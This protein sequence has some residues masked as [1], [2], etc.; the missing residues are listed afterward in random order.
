MVG[1][2]REGRELSGGGG[3]LGK[4]NEFALTDFHLF[5]PEAWSKVRC[6]SGR[7]GVTMRLWWPWRL[8]SRCGRKRATRKAIPSWAVGTSRNVW[9]TTYQVEAATGL[10]SMRESKRATKPGSRI[11]TGKSAGRPGFHFPGKAIQPSRTSHPGR[12]FC[13]PGSRFGSPR[14]RSRPSAWRGSSGRPGR[15]FLPPHRTGRCR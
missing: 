3:C 5:L 12:W 11:W 2:G 14:E 9:I 8:C 13:L 15:P 10:G 7:D 6:A 4:G 1:S